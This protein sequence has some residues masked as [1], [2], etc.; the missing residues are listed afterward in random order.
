[1]NA[2][3]HN[4]VKKMCKDISMSIESDTLP[5]QIKYMCENTGPYIYSRCKRKYANIFCEMCLLEH[6]KCN[7]TNKSCNAVFETHDF[8]S[9]DLPIASKRKD[10]NSEGPLSFVLNIPLIQ[11]ASTDGQLN[12]SNVCSEIE[13]RDEIMVST[14]LH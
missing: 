6:K 12:K 14:Y 13:Y 8:L 2:T 3:E 10:G 5:S 11:R 7:Q 4:T 1:M 9:C